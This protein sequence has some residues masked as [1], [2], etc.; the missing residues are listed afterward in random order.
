VAD[1]DGILVIPPSLAADLA[2]D[3]IAQER[4]ET[5]V[6]EMVRQGHGVDGL[7]PMN[8]AWRARFAEHEAASQHD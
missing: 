3:S 4:E 6:A 7:Y 5:F 1:A 2:E 8:T